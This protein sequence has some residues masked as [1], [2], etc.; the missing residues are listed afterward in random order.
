MLN[1]F[2]GDSR[3][4]REACFKQRGE[5]G[6]SAVSA[7]QEKQ[8]KRTGVVKSAGEVSDDRNQEKSSQ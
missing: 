6:S 2:R 7:L 5:R 1:T 3:V 4:S 8:P